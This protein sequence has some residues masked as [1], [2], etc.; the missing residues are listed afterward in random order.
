MRRF[1]PASLARWLVPA[2]T[3]VAAFVAGLVAGVE[4]VL[5]VLAAGA[6]ALVI[7]LVWASVQSLTGESAM[8]L[9]EAFSI[10]QPTPEEEQ[11]I[12]VMRALRDLSYERSVG[13]ISEEDYQSLS[14][15][16][17]TEAKRLMARI[18]EDLG[19]RRARVE[20][21]IERRLAPSSSVDGS[22]SSGSAVKGS[23]S[24]TSKTT[25]SRSR[26]STKNERNEK[27]EASSQAVATL[28]QPDVS[29]H[30]P[31]DSCGTRNDLDARFCKGCGHILGGQ[32]A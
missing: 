26:A 28:S 19:P 29:V 22:P 12:A 3:L 30:V 2:L 31:C 32:S 4:L 14:A 13:K 17:R 8:T 27:R 9:D 25:R 11:K 21:R 23:K 24:K 1:D 10:A 20:R 5:I 18:D 15:R 7:A 16:Y 6:L